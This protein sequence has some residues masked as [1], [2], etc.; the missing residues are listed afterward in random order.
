[1]VDENK[2]H[3]R[4]I[5]GAVGVFFLSFALMII[6][7]NVALAALYGTYGS[8]GGLIPIGISLILAIIWK[9]SS[10]RTVF[11]AIIAFVIGAAIVGILALASQSGSLGASSESDAS[12]SQSASTASTTSESPKGPSGLDRET[13]YLLYGHPED[14]LKN[15]QAIAV[16]KKRRIVPAGAEDDPALARITFGYLSVD[17]SWAVSNVTTDDDGKYFSGETVDELVD[18]A[19]LQMAQ[20]DP[21]V[22]E[23]A[24]KDVRSNVVGGGFVSPKDSSADPS[25]IEGNVVAETEFEVDGKSYY[26][27]FMGYYKD[28]GFEY[29]A[30]MHISTERSLG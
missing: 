7:I 1:M 3:E 25:E 29:Y 5:G 19:I 18:L 24:M 17:G 27:Y 22:S 13:Y 4:T 12:E 11:F 6:A 14:L 8:R 23:Q 15:E 30:M 26:K 28:S 10:V 9:K 20:G 16:V 21:E 2:T